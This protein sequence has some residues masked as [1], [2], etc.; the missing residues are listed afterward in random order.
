MINL[1]KNTQYDTSPLLRLGF[2]PFFF[3]SGMIAIISMLMWMVFYPSLILINNANPIDWHA[4]E[5]I[6]AY[7]SAVTV[8]FLLTASKNWTGIQTIYN[9]PLL[10]LLL[11]WV[12][13]RFLPFVTHEYLVYQAVLDTSFLIFSTLAI[14]W[15]I[16]KA[17]NWNNVSIVAKLV[18]LSVAHILFYLGLL[19]IVDQGVYFGI[20]LGFY[21]IISLLFMMSR[22]LLPFFIERGLGLKTELKNSKFLDLLSL[23]LFLGF[24]IA[25]IFFQ[26][27][28]SHILAGLLFIIH[29]I[30]L[31]NWYHKGIWKKPLLWSIYL[32]YVF[33]TLG[34]GLYVASYFIN[35]MPNISTH[36]FA[37]GIALMTLSMM[38]R[39]SLGHTGRNV[40]Q[41]PKQI[42]LMFILL[43]LAFVTRVLLV[44]IF[45][46]HYATLIFTSQLL[47]ISAFSWFA[48][49]YSPMFFKARVDGQFG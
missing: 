15:P 31:F 34:F 4:H 29:S 19:N 16:I 36:S 38:A 1:N 30:K 24:M 3:A 35:M 37:F 47:W 11:L 5:M 32:A 18:L 40:F 25:E 43:S 27:I 2:R 23:F 14:A 39:V 20:Y 17:K 49:I 13:G 8:G 26:T 28:I 42:N 41:P 10:A 44:S 9:K 46:E 48:F 6:F 22:R 12:S 7:A 45:P 21:L 33:L